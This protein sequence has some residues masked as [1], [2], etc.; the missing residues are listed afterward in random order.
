[1]YVCVHMQTHVHMCRHGKAHPCCQRVVRHR[2]IWWL[3]PRFSSTN[4]FN[5]Q[6]PLLRHRQ[7]RAVPAG[8]VCGVAHRAVAPG[9]IGSTTCPLMPGQMDLLGYD[10]SGPH[11]GDPSSNVPLICSLLH[12][13]PSPHTS[14]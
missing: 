3:G 12:F 13:P 8:A 14:L 6:N 10:L 4:N 5:I 7:G 1:M 2:C 9:P 11:L